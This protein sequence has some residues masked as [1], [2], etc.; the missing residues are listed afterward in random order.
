MRVI[1]VCIGNKI[2]L[3]SR[4]FKYTLLQKLKLA[5]M[6]TPLH[7]STTAFFTASVNPA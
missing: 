5:F 3:I 2:Y 6:I 1:W 4:L 7:K